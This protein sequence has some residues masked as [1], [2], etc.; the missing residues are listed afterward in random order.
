MGNWGNVMNII[1]FIIFLKKLEF[2]HFVW[3]IFKILV[4]VPV[5]KLTPWS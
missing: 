3:C 5:I 4:N 1:A 2:E